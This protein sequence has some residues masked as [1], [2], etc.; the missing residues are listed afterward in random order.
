MRRETEHNEVETPMPVIAEVF[1]NIGIM[2]HDVD[3]TVRGPP[4][5]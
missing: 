2:K 4:T 3:F 5:T 1:G